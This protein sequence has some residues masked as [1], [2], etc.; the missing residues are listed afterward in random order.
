MSLKCGKSLVIELFS[1]NVL[2]LSKISK[3][4][5]ELILLSK[6]LF[7]DNQTITHLVLDLIENKE[8]K[9]LIPL[10]DI[11]SKLFSDKYFNKIS[12]LNEFGFEDKQQLIFNKNLD[13]NLIQVLNQL[14]ESINNCKELDSIEMT[15]ISGRHSDQ[16]LKDF[17]QVLSQH[18]ID[19]QFLSMV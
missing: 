2:N 7:E 19:T 12:K 14:K 3:T 16:V 18:R 10:I 8:L 6:N 5:I 4:L 15:F 9:Q 1:L 11:K 17:C 13:K